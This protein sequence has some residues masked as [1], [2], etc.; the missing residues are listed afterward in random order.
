MS[1]RQAG[2]MY[3]DNSSYLDEINSLERYVLKNQSINL[4]ELREDYE[5]EEVNNIWSEDTID[6]LG[7]DHDVIRTVR[8]KK[9]GD[10]LDIINDTLSRLGMFS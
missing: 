1:I 10:I 4:L 5:N 9:T 7:R 3:E 2:N 6:Y 8:T